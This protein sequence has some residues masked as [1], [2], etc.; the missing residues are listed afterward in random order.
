[1]VQSTEANGSRERWR[2]LENLNGLLVTS[3][4]GSTKRIKKTDSANFIGNIFLN[5]LGLME[6]RTKG[7]GRKDFRMELDCSLLKTTSRKLEYGKRAST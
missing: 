5:I 4:L 3:T 7:S 1:M 6:D 2:G